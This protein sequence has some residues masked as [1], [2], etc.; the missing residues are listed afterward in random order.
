[1]PTL[2]EL[3]EYHQPATLDEA[4]K[5]LRRTSVKTVPLA[6]GTSL[7]P[8]AAR[9]V[10]AV[11]DLNALDL[12]F[13]RQEP[14]L[15]IGATTRLALMTAPLRARFGA[16]LLLC[17]RLGC[18]DGVTYARDP[19]TGVGRPLPYPVP[20]PWGFGVDRNDPLKEDLGEVKQAVAWFREWGVQL[21]NVSAGSLAGAGLPKGTPRSERGRSSSMPRSRSP[22]RSRAAF[23]DRTSWR[24]SG[25]RRSD[26]SGARAAQPH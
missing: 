6:G 8:E 14:D 9:D 26:G 12:S 19:G 20:Y 13:V 5:L 22:T 10:Q 21:L 25:R 7:V 2:R 1:M 16:R 23:A 11:V 17:M 4:L 3:T 15:E 24:P 18:Y